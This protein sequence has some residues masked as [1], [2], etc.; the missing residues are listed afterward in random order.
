MKEEGKKQS[1]FKQKVVTFKNKQWFYP[2]IYVSGA[3]IILIG[4]MLFQLVTKEPEI[5]QNSGQEQTRTE[6][7]GEKVKE[8]AVED[9][10]VRLPVAD[11]E[12]AVIA[13][14]FYE[15]S[16]DE[17]PRLFVL[18]NVHNSLNPDSISSFQ[19]YQEADLA[20]R[21]CPAQPQYFLKPDT[22][23]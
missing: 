5:S 1:P 21:V 13:K 10:F 18:Q 16:A 11:Q 19:M 8:V 22:S 4:A 3:A 15:A 20:Q 2:A 14:K 9:Q 12:K 23:L 17:A 6:Q 7:Q